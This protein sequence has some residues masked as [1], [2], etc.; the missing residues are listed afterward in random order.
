MAFEGRVALITGSGSGIGRATARIMAERGADIIVHDINAAGAQETAEQVRGTGRRV[1]VSVCDVS[2]VAAMRKTVADTAFDHI[3]I[4]V[5]NA[6][7][8][9]DRCPLEDVTEEMFAR[10]FEVH[11]KGTLFATQAVVPGMKE[12]KFGKI[13]NLSSIQGVSGFENAATY[14]GA[15]GAVL[16]MAQGWAKELAPWN[17]NVNVIAPGHVLTPMPLSRDSPESIER[18]AKSVPFGRFAQPEEMGD[19]IAFLCSREAEFITGQVISPN[20]GFLI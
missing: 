2:D 17:I 15:K 13:V 9:S 6:G 14:N 1:E 20:G 19:V 4:L 11:V 18:Q 7:I 5:N 3:D 10:S 12:R 8:P 16:A